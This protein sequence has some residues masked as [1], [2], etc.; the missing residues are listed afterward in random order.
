MS[1]EEEQWAM[2]VEDV[3]AIDDGSC[4][5]TIYYLLQGTFCIV[6]LQGIPNGVVK[7]P[8]YASFSHVLLECK[9]WIFENS[10]HN[11]FLYH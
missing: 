5:Y 11:I 8:K 3:G 6:Y 7:C 9:A 10:K 1:R 2:E 4:Q